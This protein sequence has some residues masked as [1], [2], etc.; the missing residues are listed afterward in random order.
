MLDK[1]G[2]RAG[3]NFPD[4]K[5]SYK[6][7]LFEL[8]WHKMAFPSFGYY[9]QGMGRG[10]K[11]TWGNSQPTQFFLSHNLVK[12]ITCMFAKPEKG[13]DI[14]LVPRAS[15]SISCKVKYYYLT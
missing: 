1:E 12:V 2:T 5:F 11:P 3:K 7:L 6:K 14:N 15:T 8:K 9:L 13:L 4:A 10:G